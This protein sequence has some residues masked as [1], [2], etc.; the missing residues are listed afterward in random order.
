M[1]DRNSASPDSHIDF[2]NDSVYAFLN[3][4]M[5]S[6]AADYTSISHPE[7]LFPEIIANLSDGNFDPIFTVGSCTAFAVA[8]NVSVID[9]FSGAS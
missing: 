1:P 8:E 9:C 2:K 3:N 5:F 7:I 6:A 4:K